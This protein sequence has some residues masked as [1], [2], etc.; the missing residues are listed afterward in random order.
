MVEWYEVRIV[1]KI[2]NEVVWNT[3]QC[4]IMIWIN[5]LKS[6]C[7]IATQAI[8]LNVNYNIFT[9]YADIL[10][11]DAYYL[12]WFCWKSKFGVKKLQYSRLHIL[13]YHLP[14]KRT[15]TL[16]LHAWQKFWKHHTMNVLVWNEL[17]MMLETLEVH[18]MMFSLLM[19]VFTASLLSIF[20]DRR[21]LRLGVPNPIVARYEYNLSL[22]CTFWKSNSIYFYQDINLKLNHILLL[23][24]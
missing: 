9:Y 11:T 1:L 22:R 23:R 4:G 6:A 19:N 12:V 14:K 10:V 15:S 21:P 2:L 16:H 3:W 13:L 18:K 8:G 17:D 24:K 20:C 7:F 5:A